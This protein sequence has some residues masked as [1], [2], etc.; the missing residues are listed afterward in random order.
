M[1]SRGPVT[2][3]MMMSDTEGVTLATLLLSY[4]P[5][6]I[7]SSTDGSN[8]HWTM[9]V[10]NALK[11]PCHW[12]KTQIVQNNK[13]V[14][15]L[16]RF[17]GRTQCFMLTIF[18]IDIFKTQKEQVKFVFSPLIS[19]LSRSSDVKLNTSIFTGVSFHIR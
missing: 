4:M 1:S 11:W 8:L 13:V 12:H 7:N 18:L 14:I 5:I 6:Q 16:S 15:Y 10:Q 19:W 3:W 9:N 17:V 2:F